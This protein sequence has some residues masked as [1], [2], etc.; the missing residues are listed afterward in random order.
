MHPVLVDFT[1][2]VAGTRVVLPTF[3]LFL[4]LAFLAAIQLGHHRA[5]RRGIDPEAMGNFYLV[6]IV[7]SMVGARATYVALEWERYLGRPWDVFLFWKGGLVFY[8]G[9]AGGFAG[10]LAF[11][12]LQ[13]MDVRAMADLA[14]PCLALGHLV[15]R[16][17]CFFNGCCYGLPTGAP[18]GVVFPHTAQDVAPRHPTQIYEALGLVV[19]F[20]VLSRLWE[21]RLRRGTVAVAYLAMY[22][23]LRF[24]V[25]MIRGDDRGGEIAAGLSISQVA[26]VAGLAVAGALGLALAL[27][28]AASPGE[29]R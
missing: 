12:R 20:V 14:A 1:V 3:G 26:S 16:I 5:V 2:P 13:R 15:G 17:G 11:V 22:A 23:P 25:E 9:L 10:C 7:S 6:L 19:I 4:A 21:A 8:G 28:P 29:E 18:W 27:A 24:A